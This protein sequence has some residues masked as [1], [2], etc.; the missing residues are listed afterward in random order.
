MATANAQCNLFSICQC[1]RA[2]FLKSSTGI[3][4]DS[5][6]MHTSISVLP[7]IVHVALIVAASED[8]QRKP[9]RFGQ[10]TTRHLWTFGGSL[11]EVDPQARQD[12]DLNEVGA[13]I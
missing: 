5:A 9:L 1:A 8:P 2:D 6:K 12:M 4:P 10:N 7:S 11:P 3:L 13:E